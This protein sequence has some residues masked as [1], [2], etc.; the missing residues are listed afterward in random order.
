MLKSYAHRLVCIKYGVGFVSE[1]RV[2][3]KLRAVVPE[4][5]YSDIVSMECGLIFPHS[6]TECENLLCIILFHVIAGRSRVGRAVCS[7]QIS[8]CLRVGL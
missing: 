5:D 2:S 1:T 6:F 8:K 7:E 4:N 3:T